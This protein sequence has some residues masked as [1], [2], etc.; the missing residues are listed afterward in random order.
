MRSKYAKITLK[1][2]NNISIWHA[3]GP[4]ID[5]PIPFI[6]EPNSIYT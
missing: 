4:K 1:L 3:T 6:F 5:I 2:M